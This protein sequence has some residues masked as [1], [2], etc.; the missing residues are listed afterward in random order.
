[1]NYNLSHS[2]YQQSLANPHQLAVVDNGIS[3]TYQQLASSASALAA[4]LQTSPDWP[5]DKYTQP[6]VAILGSRSALACMAVLGASWAG[7]TYIPLGTKLPEERIVTLLQMCKVNAVIA[8]AEGTKLLTENVLAA[9][10]RLVLIPSTA[11]PPVNHSSLKAYDIQS[12]TSIQSQ[13]AFMAADVLAYIIFTSGTTGVPKGVIITCGAIQHYVTMVTASL[14]LQASDR[15]IET[16]ELTFDVSL[17]TMFTTWQAGASLH[18]LPATRV[19]N[20]VK[21]VNEHQV[22]VWF[23]V[24]SLAGMLKEIKTLTPNSLASLRVSVFGGE[25]LPEG[26]I[27]AWQ[28]AAPNS[29]IENYYGPTEAT[30]FCLSQTVSEPLALTP[31]RDILSIGTPMP[32]NEAAVVDSS[33]AFLP[34]G[35]I[36]ELALSGVQLSAGYLNAPE[37]TKARFPIIGGKRWYLTGDLAMQDA[38]GR[39]HCLGRLDHQ[40]KILGYRVELEEV[41]TYLRKASNNGVAATVAWPILDG[42]AQGLVGFVHA[43]TIDANAIK[44]AMKQFLPSYMVPSRVVAIPNMPLN[45]SG[46]IDR[47]ALINLLQ[48]NAIP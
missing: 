37:L 46:K 5:I 7:A 36:G 11:K 30:V 34:P 20:A 22:T 2:V 16:L 42:V 41:D 10:P 32:S 25:Q 45:Q 18:I 3:Y 1:M 17:H 24:P 39:F 43:D 23:S 35:E 14:G 28:Q 26:V 48:T 38:D 4:L 33:L 12:A 27:K 47:K 13:P 8:D 15:A 40:V 29:R 6:R 21:F 44:T 19:M 9:C 31:G